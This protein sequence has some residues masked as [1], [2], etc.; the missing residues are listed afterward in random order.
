MDLGSFPSD[1]RPNLRGKLDEI[2]PDGQSALVTVMVETSIGGD[3][4]RIYA[5]SL[6][7]LEKKL[8]IEGGYDARYVPSGH[9][10]FART[11]VLMAVPFDLE[12]LEVQGEPQV[13]LKGVSME[14]L[15]GQVQVSFSDTGTLVY[16]PGGDATV[17]RIA[18]VDRQGRTELLPVP[19]RVYGVF[20]LSPNDQQLAVQVADVNDYIWI[21][22]LARGEG[23]RLAGT[24]PN[25]RPKWNRKGDRIA[26]TARGVSGV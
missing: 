18:R 3:S 22:D 12:R 19:E 16:A 14:S 5:L 8:L 10:L 26:F 15:F 17:G 1:D 11:G 7:T 24:G 9:L 25:G 4:A 20:D 6:E 23:R 2:L 21:Y 13:V